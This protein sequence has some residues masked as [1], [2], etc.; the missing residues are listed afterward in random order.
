MAHIDYCYRLAQA[1]IC[2]VILDEI[3]GYVAIPPSIYDLAPT[4]LYYAVAT[5]SLITDD[6]EWW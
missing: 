1:Y 4:N 3:M 2:Q 5:I 6:Q